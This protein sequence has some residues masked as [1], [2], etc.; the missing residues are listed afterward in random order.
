MKQRPLFYLLLCVLPAGCSS[1][2]PYAF[3]NL[4]EAPFDCFDKY[5]LRCQFRR[6]AE[7]AWAQISKGHNHSRAYED[8]F[9]TGFVEFLDGN[10][11]GE[12]PG[13]P[14]WRYRRPCFLTPDGQVAIQDWYAGFR[15]G[16]D[17]A[18]A[19]GYREAVV[20][21]PSLPPRRAPGPQAPQVPVTSEPQDEAVLPM[22]RTVTPEEPPQKQP[23][24][25]LPAPDPKVRPGG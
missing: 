12:P 13:E 17:V 11:T 6:M 5:C 8:G 10:G 3:H 1:Y 4:V 15:H 24:E 22:P 2:A 21:P 14:P 23:P 18:R 19:T 20:V 7:D 16:A 9:S 25:I